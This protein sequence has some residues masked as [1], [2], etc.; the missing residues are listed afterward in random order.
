MFVPR[1]ISVAKDVALKR[2]GACLNYHGSD[3]VEGEIRARQ[4]AMV[5]QRADLKETKLFSV[6]PTLF[7]CYRYFKRYA[8]TF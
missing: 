1:T 5:S 3:C 4:V 8:M 2:A 6:F 7:F